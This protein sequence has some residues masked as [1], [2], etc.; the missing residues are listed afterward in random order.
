MAKVRKADG[1]S[2]AKIKEFFDGFDVFVDNIE[3][4]SKE[5]GRTRI[6]LYRS[7]K[8]AADAIKNGLADGIHDFTFLK[9]RQLGISTF[10]Y[11]LS[12]YYCSLFEALKGAMVFDT[13]DNKEEFR[14]LLTNS[15]ESLPKRLQIGRKR[16]NRTGFV[17][18][19]GSTLA[20]LV[21]GTRKTKGSGGLGRS[22]GL[23]FVHSTECSSYADVEG[24]V[25]LRESLAETNPN[26]LF[27]WESTARGYGNVFYDMCQEAKA[28]DLTR[29]FCFIGWWAHDGHVIGE[30][31]ELF[32]RYGRDDPTPL[33]LEKLAAVWKLYNWQITR[34][35]LAWIRWK[36]DPRRMLGERE[37][38]G[39]EIAK[40]ESEE[41][42]QQE[43]PWVEEEAFILSGSQF[44]NPVRINTEI[45]DAQS[46]S[47]KG[48]R[49]FL[50]DS[51]AA[52]QDVE[53]AARERDVMLKV[54]EEPVVDG[55]Y[56]ISADPAFAGSAKSDRYCAEVLRA[57]ADGIDQVAEFCVPNIETFQFTWVLAHLA[58][59]Y[60]NAR[61]IIEKNG[62]G[63]A[64]MNGFRELKAILNDGY[65]RNATTREGSSIRNMLQGVRNYMYTRPDSLRGDYAFQWRTTEQSKAAMF[66]QLRD[67]FTQSQLK[68]KSV[69][70][71]REMRNIVK[72]GMQ[73]RAEGKNKDDRPMAL[74]MGVRAWHDFDRKFLVSSGRTREIELARPNL[75]Q[76]D[77]NR[78]F[79]SSLIGNTL[80]RAERER[81][82]SDDRASRGTR[83]NF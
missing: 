10:L 36:M 25:S 76:E 45:A 52:S 67:A 63:E 15:L 17:F 51:F 18:N 8:R 71:L 21:A 2:D 28:D 47:F 78:L 6:K 44:F 3:V 69:E 30:G 35:Q 77:I 40:S 7:Q 39:G 62:P 48:Y 42:R 37:A 22:K 68:L 66:E 1:W 31:T 13:G 5:L 33:E 16:D 9:S 50:G 70:A 29:R 46:A 20:Y 43:Q 83:W 14:T 73:I 80:K 53:P 65:L 19:N 75:T 58:G 24:L 74:A 27:A 41:L 59:V 26:R 23:S 54:W 12:I 32:E 49:Y 38:A 64:V 82:E 4:D 34:E 61:L 72:D 81:A 60:S 56:I 11:L 79:F 57:Y 55:V